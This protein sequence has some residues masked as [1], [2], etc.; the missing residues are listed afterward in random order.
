MEDDDD[1]KPDMEEDADVK[2]ELAKPKK[3][4]KKGGDGLL[5]TCSHC[6]KEFRNKR[7]RDEHERVHTGEKPF[8]CKYCPFKASSRGNIRKHEAVRHHHREELPL[9]LL[10]LPGQ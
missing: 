2:D 5:H 9:L 6:G 3:K 4:R 8:T 10:L 7:D 1:V